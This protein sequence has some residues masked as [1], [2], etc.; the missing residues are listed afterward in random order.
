[1]LLPSLIEHQHCSCIRTRQQLD[2]CCC[3]GGVKDLGEPTQGRQGGERI[4]TEFGSDI[5]YDVLSRGFA[6]GSDFAWI[7]RAE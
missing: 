5:W 3:K 7:A 6:Q 4:R 2:T 1:M